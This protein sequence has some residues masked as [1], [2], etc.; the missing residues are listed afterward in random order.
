MTP[1]VGSVVHYMNNGKCV[2]AMVMGGAANS[3]DLLA[4]TKEAG[5]VS[6]RYVTRDQ[7]HWPCDEGRVKAA[8][9]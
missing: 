5:V 3:V 9:A 8:V 2:P 7:W 1:E 6:K 4:H